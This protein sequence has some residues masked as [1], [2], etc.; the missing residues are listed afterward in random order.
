M[1]ELVSEDRQ[2]KSTVLQIMPRRQCCLPPCRRRCR[3][4]ISSVSALCVNSLSCA[5]PCAIAP[6]RAVYGAIPRG[7]SKLDAGR[8][9]Y[10]HWRKQPALRQIDQPFLRD[11]PRKIIF[12]PSF[13]ALRAV[14]SWQGAGA[15]LNFSLSGNVFLVGKLSSKNTKFGLGSPIWEPE[16]QGQ[17]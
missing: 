17:N 7:S 8:G 6:W 3:C 9:A 14:P 4:I 11:F 5:S 2:R 15:P 13:T 10:R 1:F 12:A 16:I